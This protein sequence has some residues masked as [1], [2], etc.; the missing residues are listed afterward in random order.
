MLRLRIEGRL[1]PLG[2]LVADG[3]RARDWTVRDAAGLAVGR[4]TRGAP[5]GSRGRVGA[6]TRTVRVG[7]D[8]PE[9]L[10]TLVAV[11]PLVVALAMQADSRGR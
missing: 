3:W 8:V 7:P 5:E 2:E 10:R 6:Q 4:V 1:G 9:P 11:S